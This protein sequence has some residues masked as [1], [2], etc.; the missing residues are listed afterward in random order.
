MVFKL[1]RQNNILTR[2][3]MTV[4]KKCILH[5]KMSMNYIYGVG[6]E[7]CFCVVSIPESAKYAT[8]K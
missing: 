1:F 8:L 7:F 4:W 5:I 3:V 2:S 6:F